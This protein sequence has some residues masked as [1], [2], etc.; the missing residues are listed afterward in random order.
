M[1]P[2]EVDTII[3]AYDS[4]SAFKDVD[5]A[6][7]NLGALPNVECVIF[8][9][10]TRRMIDNSINGSPILLKHRKAFSKFISVDHVQS[11][12]PTPQVY[13][14]LAHCVDRAGDQSAIWLVSGNPFDIVGARS[15]GLN[16]AWVDRDK[17]GWQDKLGPEP[18]KIIHSLSD[19][20]ELARSL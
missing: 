3:H 7:Q 11:F 6:L 14:Y 16:A 8:S 5:P 12:K 17:H 1:E 13:K 15:A 18:S 19:L 4:L 2:G 20:V 10:G 9:N